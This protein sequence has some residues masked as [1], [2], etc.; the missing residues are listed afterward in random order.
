MNETVLVTG[1]RGFVAGW[2]IVGLLEQGYRVR[3]TL[4][5]LSQETGV[6]DAIRAGVDPGDRLSFEVAD[7]TADGGWKE[8]ADG[9]RYV[10]HVASPLGSDASAGS[11]ALLAPARDGTLRVLAAALAARV[12][13]VVMTSACAA[14]TP[15][16]AS[17]D[18]VTDE[19]VWSD[20]DDPSMTAYRKSKVV[21]ERA[22]WE[23]MDDRGARDSLTTILPGAVFG[24]VLSTDA[25]GSVQ[26]IGRLVGGKFA[27]NPRVGFEVVDVRDLADAHIRAMTCAEAGG[28]RIIA[29]GEFMWTSEISA[30]LRDALGDDGR[31]LPTRNLPNSVV[32]VAA[33]FDPGVKAIVP[34]LG[35]KHLHSSAKA[36]RLLGWEARPAAQTVIGCARDLITRGLIPS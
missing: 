5:S 7:L 24:P 26:V 30:V 15:L 3:A 20:P 13:R 35:R 28:E 18:S 16:M 32:R 9:C 33:R 10:L 27:G 23:F 31:R 21:A 1:G 34:T 25:L 19:T 17:P 36:Q 14:A 29:A 6:R 12:E 11:D 22:A 2:C 8:A 4:R